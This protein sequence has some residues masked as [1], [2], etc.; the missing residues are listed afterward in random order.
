M[1]ADVSCSGHRI[2]HSKAKFTRDEKVK[3]ARAN[4]SVALGAI[5]TKRLVTETI[6]EGAET[7]VEE[8]QKLQCVSS[9]R[10]GPYQRQLEKKSIGED[11][12]ILLATSTEQ[13]SRHPQRDSKQQKSSDLSDDLAEHLHRTEKPGMRA[14]TSTHVAT[15]EI[16]RKSKQDASVSYSVCVLLFLA[17]LSLRVLSVLI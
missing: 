14:R 12:E 13:M 1:D 5:K 6:A 2:L 9:E 17:G 3:G 11:E 16:A 7:I 10:S 8:N 15:Q 4:S